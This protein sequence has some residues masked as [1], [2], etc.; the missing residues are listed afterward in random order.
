MCGLGVVIIK[1]I[2]ESQINEGCV[3][4]DAIEGYGDIGFFM[5]GECASFVNI[6]I[7]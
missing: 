6:Q 2:K 1:R 7:N 4:N 5:L 3:P